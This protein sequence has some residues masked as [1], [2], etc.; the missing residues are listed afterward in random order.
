MDPS[1]ALIYT[2]Q[3]PTFCE[4]IELY[5]PTSEYFGIVQNILPDSWTINKKGFWTTCFPGN[6]NG[7]KHGWK[8]HVSSVL[9]NAS[10]TVSIV[11]AE[12]E[13][14]GVAFKFASD[15]RMLKISLGKTWSRFQIGKFIAI[16]PRD[17]EQF[18]QTLEALYQ[19]T[20]HLVGPH[21]LTDR[22]YRDSRVVF[23]R[24]GAFASDYRLNPYGHRIPGFTLQEGAWYEDV[25]GPTYRLPPGISDPFAVAHAQTTTS[26]PPGEVLLANRYAVRGAIKFSATGGIYH[27][28]DNSNGRA[29]VIREVNGTLG[30][31]EDEM[32]GDPAFALKR[33][34]KILQRLAS[35]G[36]VP[37]FVDLFKEWNNW[38]LVEEKLD[39]STLWHHSMDI[40]VSD[41]SQ[42]ASIGFDRISA[43]IE[44]IANG[45][46]AV[47]EKGV[48][49]RD[50]T[51]TNVLLTADGKVKF[52][53]FEFAYE[54][55]D[56]AP[57]VKG[58]TPGYAS[59]E[60]KTHERP[61]PSDD[62]YAFGALILDIVTFS[63]AGL[64]LNR[65]AIL[66]KMKQNLADLNLPLQL[67][68]MVVGLMDPD[69]K[70][71][72]DVHKALAHLRAIPAGALQG[73]MLPVRDDF[74]KIE[75]PTPQLVRELERIEQQLGKFFDASGDFSRHDR[76]WP[77]SA[78]M[79]VTNPVSI[80]FGAAGG[81]FFLLRSRN[82]IDP[83]VVDWIEQGA[84]AMSCPPGL[85]A[86]LSGVALLLMEAGRIDAAQKMLI[87]AGEDPLV[88]AV[89][90][91]YFGSAGWGLANLHLWK[92][93]GARE[94]L[95]RAV[96]VGCKL[97]AEAKSAP[98]GTFWPAG[99]KV[100]LGLGEGQ[101]GIA[102]FLMLLGVA[103][104]DERFIRAAGQALDF[105]IAH[106]IRFSDKILW[107]THAAAKASEPNLP[108]TR[109]GTSGIGTACIRYFAITADKKYRDIAEDCAYTLRSRVTN[110]MW[111]DNGNAGFGEFML[112][113]AHFLKDERYRDLAYYQAEAIVPHALACNGGVAFAG[114]DHF[115]ICSDYGHGGAGIG[116][117]I[118]RLLH[119]QSRFLMLDELIKLA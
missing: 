23:Y 97:L 62:Y 72:W 111:Q 116:I 78:D 75:S 51:K 70:T 45:L 56:T 82:A 29:I 19:V 95:D 24:Y 110:K 1:T 8:I 18:K 41:E 83:R 43:T 67:Y 60:Q 17:L 31:L 9:S 81:A 47:H 71:R 63:S 109:H 92:H 91:L 49:L 48:V 118:S 42:Q 53:D 54:L 74:F 103:A 3:N 7:P 79:F 55:D 94:Y 33:E 85:Y 96:E 77:S 39:A 84:S 99:G 5:E 37:E 66:Q 100:Q 68:D 28:V 105:D 61:S 32:P 89:P 90:G 59:V 34:A 25:R 13:K 107:K 104:D 101:G 4:N 12:L 6:W 15:P 21:I 11:A 113:M 76:L 50:L 38:F 26:A 115:R 114:A 73:T 106:G 52:I 14:L 22:P 64:E 36:V 112:D 57:W 93:T 16:Y 102:L 117:F 40:Y 2:F 108:H 88:H 86:G 87:K 65:P 10:E 35:T 69:A 119:Q 58:F 80:Q 44:S 27:G 30:H 20:G 46:L 98:M